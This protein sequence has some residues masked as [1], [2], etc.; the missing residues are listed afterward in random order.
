MASQ[1]TGEAVVTGRVTN[2]GGV[3]IAGAAVAVQGSPARGTSAK[4]GS[5]TLSGAPAGTQLVL[6]RLVGYDPVQMPLDITTKGPNTVTVRLGDYHPQL[7]PVA[8]HAKV[9]PTELDRTGFPRRKKR[10]L[11]HYL[12]EDDITREQP[13][14]TSDALREIMGLHVLGGGANVSITTS[15][16]DGCVNYLIDRNSI[17][18]NDGQSI[19]ELV[20]PADIVGIEFYQP[21]EIPAELATGA[22]SGCALLVVW[23]RS[24]L[25]KSQTH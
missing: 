21:S 11:G 8:V 23:T 5:F 1:Q 24:S 2:K 9:S 18:P 25:Q 13:I 14:F 10:G 3:P 6:V 19:D 22:N 16:G 15:R 12:T 7:A 20:R 4:D 17:T